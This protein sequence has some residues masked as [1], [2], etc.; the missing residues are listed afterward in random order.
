MGQCKWCG[1]STVVGSGPFLKPSWKRWRCNACGVFGYVNEPSP[2]DLSEV[3][4]S[5]WQE[6]NLG[7]AF[8][9]GSTTAQIANSLLSAVKWTPSAGN[10]LDYGG[11]KGY[12]A[13]ALLMRG[14]RSLSVYEPFG[15]FPGLQSVNWVNDLSQLGS[16][17]FDWIFM[18]EVL[19]HL[20][21][22]QQELETVRHLLSSGGKLLVT[23]PNAKGWRARL[24]GFNW[25]EAQNPTHINLFSEQTL[26][27][28]LIKA[29]YSSAER[30]LRPVTYRAQGFKALALATTQIF[31]VDGGLRFVASNS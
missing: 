6:P 23:T 17:R 27:A 15:A 29:G 14:C 3:Y 8:A 31:G 13:S 18:V 28:N 7:G 4:K 25:R 20:L 11:G 9:A 22:P 1:G 19:E 30:I 12:F 5:A 10:C 26:K 21:D 2:D 24:D 16:E